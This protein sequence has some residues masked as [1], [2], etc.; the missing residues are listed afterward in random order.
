MCFFN[1]TIGNTRQDKT[2]Q[3]ITV[4]TKQHSNYK[5][6]IIEIPAARKLPIMQSVS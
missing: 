5:I 4:V 1:R 3:S 6:T 2:T